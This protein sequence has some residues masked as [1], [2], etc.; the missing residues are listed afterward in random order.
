MKSPN[1]STGGKTSKSSKSPSVKKSSKELITFTLQRPSKSGKAFFRHVGNKWFFRPSKKLGAEIDGA[2]KRCGLTY[3]EYGSAFAAESIKSYLKVLLAKRYDRSTSK[4][5]MEGEDDAGTH[6]LYRTKKGK[7]FL[8]HRTSFLDGK[9]VSGM[10]LPTIAP[11]LFRFDNPNAKPERARRIT[12]TKAVKPLTDIEAL[13]WVIDTQ[14]THEGNAFIR[15]A[16]KSG[17]MAKAVG[18]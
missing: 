4:L 11:E 12:V 13:N 6:E 9:Q 16:V 3:E 7:Y 2:L 5:L 15:A 10:R 14:G 1:E 17:L 18:K 8:W